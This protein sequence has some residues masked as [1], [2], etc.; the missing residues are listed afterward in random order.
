MDFAGQ[1]QSGSTAHPGRLRECPDCGML[2]R[3]PPL[4]RGSVAHCPRCN[5]V[6]RRRRADPVGRSLALAVTGLLLLG[7]AVWL[8]FLDVS[9]G[10]Q[11]R[12][13]SLFSGP[14][15]LE[16]NGVWELA[17]A[18][19]ATTIGAPLA[20]L[21]ALIYVL[22]GLSLPHPPRHL[23]AVFRWVE[24]LSPWSMI[25]VFLL[26]VFV[27][28]T[29]LTALAE[30]ELGG[31]VYALAGLMLA[32]AAADGVLDHEAVWEGLEGCGVVAAAVEPREP[33]QPDGALAPLHGCDSCGLVSRHVLACPRCGGRSRPRKQDSLSRT[34]SLLAAAA[35]LY[36]PAN[37]LPVL[38]VVRIGRGEPS[39]ILGG[40]LELA[41][42]ENWPLA[43][44]VLF[45]S[46][47]VPLLKL[48]GLSVLLIG[49]HRGAQSGLRER[50][51][52]YR[53]VESVGRW[54][55]IDV[56]MI[57]I[58]TAMVRMGSLASVYP[59]PGAVAFCAVVILTMLAAM[60]FDPRLMWDA[61][62]RPPR[63]KD[64]AGVRG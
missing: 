16:Q 59:G 52:L 54:S 41:T 4:P 7:L 2:Q 27:A 3:L 37:L 60:T 6:L 35:I 1:A 28:Y 50:T 56:F 10:G 11:G 33:A 64:H 25:E 12:Q 53:V 38:T 8:P 51:R 20:R 55:M 14:V 40:V 58:L 30:V 18:V 43:V 13:S 39:T 48:V 34:W 45:A 15:A 5:A 49:T 61:A 47:V 9:I 23:Y 63:E 26:G 46:V 22:A 24:W 42:P 17:L 57:S 62:A 32:T 31:A 29:R 19:L 21:L 36:I 44:L